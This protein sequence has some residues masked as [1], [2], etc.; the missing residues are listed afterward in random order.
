[1]LHLNNCINVLFSVILALFLVSEEAEAQKMT[2]LSS[3]IDSIESDDNCRSIIK[4]Y[5]F[6]CLLGDDVRHIDSSSLKSVCVRPSFFIVCRELL[7]TDSYS[8]FNQIYEDHLIWDDY[9]IRLLSCCPVKQSV[10]HI[11]DERL[12]DKDDVSLRCLMSVWTDF[13]YE[14]LKNYDSFKRRL[15]NMPRREIYISTLAIVN[16]NSMN[17]SE[18]RK[19][20]R[21]LK[22]A[23]PNTFEYVTD[24]ISKNAQ[25]DIPSFE[26]EII[27]ELLDISDADIEYRLNYGTGHT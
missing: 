3:F 7:K 14:H 4:E 13:E 11:I 5:V 21:L 9:V 17:K 24:L 27:W 19:L 6:A 20:L 23:S 10:Y 15:S 22:Y 8:K 18:V 25:I 26:T 16:H 1:M 2:R 12:T